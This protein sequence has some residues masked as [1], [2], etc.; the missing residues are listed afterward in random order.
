MGK[1]K[2]NLDTIVVVCV[3]I[4]MTVSGLVYFAKASDLRKVEYRLDQKI[5]QDN[6]LFLKRQLWSLWRKHNTKECLRMPEPDATMCQ[7]FRNELEKRGVR[8]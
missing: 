2:D 1:I 7:G 3:I 5:K 4:G 8:L 6:V